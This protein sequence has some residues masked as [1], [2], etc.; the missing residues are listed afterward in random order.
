MKKYLIQFIFLSL[1]FNTTIYVPHDYLSIQEAINVSTDND[2]ILVSQGEYYENINYFGKAIVLMG[3]DKDNTIIN[4]SQNSSVVIFESE[5]NNN[6]ILDG[7]SIINGKNQYGGGIHLNNSNP[8]IRNI[9]LYNNIA[10]GGGGAGLYCLDAD[11]IIKYVNIFNNNSDD[12]GGGIYL[13][14]NSNPRCSNIAIYQNNS[15]GAGGGVYGE[16]V[17]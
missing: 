10:E 2:T 7:F 16:A 11:P 15:S 1:C 9:N 8:I 17:E 14:G 12:V 5:E 3:E 6:S 13:K 4:G